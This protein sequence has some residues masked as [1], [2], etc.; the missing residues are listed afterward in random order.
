[1]KIGHENLRELFKTYREKGECPYIY[2]ENLSWMDLNGLDLT[3]AV[4]TKTYLSGVNFSNRT[5]TGVR[6]HKCSLIDTR[7]DNCNINDVSFSGSDLTGSSFN[8]A[9]ISKSFFNYADLHLSEFVGSHIAFCNFKSSRIRRADLMDAT[10][11]Y[12]DFSDVYY[13]DTGLEG[14]LHLTRLEAFDLLSL[15]KVVVLMCKERGIY[16]KIENVINKLEVWDEI[17]HSNPESA[18]TEKLMFIVDTIKRW[19]TIDVKIKEFQ[20]RSMIND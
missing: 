8:R 20:K 6:F 16:L 13:E 5:L 17:T 9:K 15:G 19:W 10:I 2:G 7:F 11:R 18:D 14:E 3:G 12:S 4:F 1:M